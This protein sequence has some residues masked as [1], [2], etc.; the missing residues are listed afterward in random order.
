ML[1]PSRFA[2]LLTLAAGGTLSSRLA[3]D[4]FAVLLKEVGSPAELAKRHGLVQESDVGALLAV[5][6]AVLERNP[7]VTEDFLGGKG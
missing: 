7:S 1:P 3:R 2:E 5:A 6:E 4:L